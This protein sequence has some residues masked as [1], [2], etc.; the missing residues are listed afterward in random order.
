MLLD[1]GWV[2]TSKNT[3]ELIVRDKKEAR[4]C[5]PL[6]VQVVIET[7]LAPLQTI[8]QVLQVC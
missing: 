5:V 1:T 3:E 8:T 7:L 4:K 2:T 6:R